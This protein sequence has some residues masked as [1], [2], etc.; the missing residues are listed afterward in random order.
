MAEKELI[1]AENLIPAELFDGK[2]LDPILQRIKDQVTGFVPN[3]ET[4][5]GRKEIASMA[6]KV[7]KS[8]VI[9]DDLGKSLVA[10]WKEKA[11]T[12]DN[13]RK[14]MRDYL[15]ALKD[16]VRQPLTE[17][18]EEERARVEKIESIINETR[19]A[20][21]F[22]AQNW[23]T[24]P[25]EAMADRLKE[26]K[27]ISI[28]ES[29]GDH[30]GLAARVKDEAIVRIEQAIG[31]REKHDAEQAELARL[32]KEAAEREAKEREERIAAEAA[33]RAREEAEA[34][35]KAEADR[36]ER[37]RLE[38]EKKV[39]LDRLAAEQRAKAEADRIEREKQEEIRKRE[40][41]ERQ[42]KEANERAA[43]AAELA[44]LQEQ[45]RQR[46]AEEKKREEEERREA[47]KQNRKRVLA[48]A[49][50][51]IVDATGAGHE[52]VSG[53]VN[54]IADGK[55]KHIYIRW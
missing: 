21:E 50:M 43:K 5:T 6:H 41:A 44:R 46:Q 20:G 30:A 54:A 1:V 32:R 39:E 48:E 25:P 27:A 8:K 28:D 33:N 13:E 26:I 55:A 23:I 38:S 45:E 29:F 10:G 24:L 15:D 51:S 49:V 42:V 2:G 53:I 16:E 9:L 3:L 52:Q 7:A 35:A 31:Q 4:A 47:D 14:R 37:E 18:E 12:V 36:V 17:W 11:K 22:T 19:G 34:K 40:E